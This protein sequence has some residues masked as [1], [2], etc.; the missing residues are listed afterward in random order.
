MLW[1]IIVDLLGG[2][3]RIS[4]TNLT[5][6]FSVEFTLIKTPLD[7]LATQPLSPRLFAKL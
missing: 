1:S 6:S 4:F 7:V 2:F 3:E 5:T